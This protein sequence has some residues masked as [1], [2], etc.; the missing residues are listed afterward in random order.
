MSVTKNQ[1]KNGPKRFLKNQLIYS[2][3]VKF[4][5]LYPFEKS[6]RSTTVML[7][8]HYVGPGPAQDVACRANKHV[9][10][11]RPHELIY[12]IIS[13]GKINSKKDVHDTCPVYPYCIKRALGQVTTRLVGP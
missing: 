8:L 10:E 13:R 9:H 5:S 2:I 3:D 6:L 1:Y 12:F 11:K 7:C 4:L